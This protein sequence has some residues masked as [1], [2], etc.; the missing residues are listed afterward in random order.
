L[1]EDDAMSDTSEKSNDDWVTTAGNDDDDVAADGGDAS[2]ATP[3]LSQDVIPVVKP[4]SEIIV[5]QLVTA[6]AEAKKIE[7]TLNDAIADLNI[8][9]ADEVAV[10][11]AESDKQRE[12]LSKTY[13]IIQEQVITLSEATAEIRSSSDIIVTTA[14]A[15]TL[16]QAWIWGL[17]YPPWLRAV[18]KTLTNSR[19]VMHTETLKTK[20]TV[21]ATFAATPSTKLGKAVRGLIAL[22]VICGSARFLYA[23]RPVIA[24]SITAAISAVSTVVTKKRI[25]IAMIAAVGTAAA[26]YLCRPPTPAAITPALGEEN[27]SKIKITV[28]EI[29][30]TSAVGKRLAPLFAKA[31]SGRLL[32][33]L[34]LRTALISPSARQSFAKP[35]LSPLCYPPQVLRS[36]FTRPAS[37]V[38]PSA[39]SSR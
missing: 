34:Q 24:Q 33:L 14:S 17:L 13:A 12:S 22:F 28:K 35:F 38:S 32:S 20:A 25:G 5:D 15:A 8:A 27:Q 36:S 21:G 26:V 10:L 2:S 9:H 29:L 37:S 18:R 19:L 23:R 30:T 31:S 11:K 4:W 16:K 6:Q 3:E 1:L 39:S 7:T